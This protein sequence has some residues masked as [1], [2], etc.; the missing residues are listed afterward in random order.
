MKKER[1][2]GTCE[3]DNFANKVAKNDSVLWGYEDCHV[4]KEHCVDETNNVIIDWPPL[5]YPG[6][7]PACV[8]YCPSKLN[9]E[10][11]EFFSK[12]KVDQYQTRMWYKINDFNN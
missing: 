4:C 3:Y 11:K 6:D 10:Y 1:F 12:G 8:G 7:D 9:I 5:P 2:G